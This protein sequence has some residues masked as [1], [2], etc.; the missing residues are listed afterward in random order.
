LNKNKIKL[1]TAKTTRAI[2]WASTRDYLDYLSDTRRILLNN[3][4]AG[5]SRGVGAAIGFSLLGALVI[6]LISLL[7]AQNIPVI[8]EFISD[9][10]DVIEKNTK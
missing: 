8:G 4:V 1:T 6:Y 5:L 9:I 2:A 3:F 10:M 7:A